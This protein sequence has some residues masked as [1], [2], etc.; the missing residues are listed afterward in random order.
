MKHAARLI[1]FRCTAALLSAAAFCFCINSSAF[2]EETDPRLAELKK[3]HPPLMPEQAAEEYQQHYNYPIGK[4]S[5]T[6][7]TLPAKFDLRDGATNGF[8]ESVVTPVE[9][10]TLWSTCW[11]FAG[12]SAIESNA[13][14][15][16]FGSADQI[17]LSERFPAWFLFQ[18][19][20]GEGNAIIDNEVS[21]LNFGG[22]AEKLDGLYASWYGPISE[23][24]A[25]YQNNDGQP[26]TF[27]DP[28]DWSLPDSLMEE[29]PENIL[30]RL[31]SSEYLP[32]TTTYADY[33]NHT[34]Y[35]M[36]EGALTALKTALMEQGV[37]SISYYSGYFPPGASE[38]W[39]NLIVN[40]DEQAWYCPQYAIVNHAVSIVGWDDT[41]PKEN[42]ISTPPDNGA[43]IV[44]N[45]YGSNSDASDAGLVDEEGYFYLSYYD[46]TIA[47]PV[48]YQVELPEDGLYDYDYNYQYDYL[49]KKGTV[50]L[51]P[52]P[53][54]TGAKAANVFHAAGKEWLHAISAT[55]MNPD[56]LVEVEIYRLPDGAVDPD[57]GDLVADF[58][59]TV[60][61]GGYHTLELPEPILLNKGETF[62]VIQTITGSGGGYLPVEYST[63]PTEGSEDA[64]PFLYQSMAV[65]NPGESFLQDPKNGFWIDLSN[66]PSTVSPERT[67]A[68]GNVLIKAFTTALDPIPAGLKVESFAADGT[69]LGM[70]DISNFTNVISL[71]AEAAS[72]VLNLELFAEGSAELFQ[73]EEAYLP[74]TKIS[75]EDLVNERFTLQLTTVS[76]PR[77]NNS[78]TF[79]LR[80]EQPP[81]PSEP[82]S[83]VSSE[84]AP[85]S[86]E[87]ESS[88][89]DASGTDSSKEESSE[90]TSITVTVSDVPVLTK[91]VESGDTNA[92]PVL[93]V[94]LV[95][96][97]GGIVALLVYKKRS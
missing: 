91:P 38:E 61:F 5:H 21:C 7:R 96:S 6:F 88:E 55:T 59:E 76:A 33:E 23:E 42:F 4:S 12:N 92:L 67:N 74:E 15:N 75:A 46:Q 66:Y 93:I 19:F 13:I 18:P 83:A 54:N 52:D 27:E 81:L 25:P 20:H 73:N 62:S 97:A 87:A 84:P 28:G 79:S 37:L 32:S 44:K 17:D 63:V 70:M 3:F 1:F 51:V 49:A 64:F 8:G 45:S 26:G 36:D 30:L 11:A 22:N 72:I 31:K 85:P 58:E 94:L 82:E 10:Q 24:L 43:W 95:L 71:P 60:S 86:S 40:P 89:A 78:G 34:G 65:V 77:N 68:F 50:M 56:S 35:T 41:Y 53:G 47:K 57:D 90:E 9:D 80:F 39:E 16:G 29:A 2:A 69:S 48:S 14:I